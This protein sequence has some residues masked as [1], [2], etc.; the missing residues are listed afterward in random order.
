M[1]PAGSPP[2]GTWKRRSTC[3]TGPSLRVA[4]FA[5]GWRTIR[6]WTPCGGCRASRRSSRAFRPDLRSAALSPSAIQSVGRFAIRPAGR[7]RMD[8]IPVPAG[9]GLRPCPGRLPD[10][11]LDGEKSSR[12]TGLERAR[13]GKI[14]SEMRLHLSWTRRKHHDPIAEIESFLRVVSDEEHGLAPPIPETGERVLH[15]GPRLGVEGAKRLVEQEDGRI[16][17]EHSRHLD[18]LRH[19]RGQLLRE[20]RLERREADEAEELVAHNPPRCGSNALG[21][22]AELQVFPH[23]HPGK[24]GGFLQDV[25]P[26][27]A[28]AL[29]ARAGAADRS[30][31]RAKEPGEDAQ[32]RR[33]PAAY[34]TEQGQELVL[35]DLEAQAF[36]RLRRR[37]AGIGVAD[38]QRLQQRRGGI[39]RHSAR[40]IQRVALACKSSARR[41]NT[42]T[43]PPT[44]ATP[45]S[46]VGTRGYAPES[47]S[48]YP[49]LGI[50]A[51]INSATTI[52][53]HASPA[54]TRM[55]AKI[56]GNAA[57][58]TILRKHSQRLAPSEAAASRYTRSTPRT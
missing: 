1:P 31:R 44:V 48:R 17:R 23:R 11:P 38:V 50:L 46:M 9:L 6:T 56:E 37:Q 40:P 41:S 14:D 51:S 54:A 7:I 25:S 35:L 24:D 53:T 30:L 15:P 32:Q 20:R 19:A 42:S 52:V 34:G 3:S 10:L 45:I 27:P 43:S 18:H 29:D 28:G 58:R 13:P 49:R 2:R 57:G 26:L 39:R 8:P 4:A 16:G 22:K 21:E 5:P 12:E 47:A 33:L 55:L 36:Q